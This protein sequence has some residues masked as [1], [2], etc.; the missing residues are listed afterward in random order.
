MDVEQLYEELARIVSAL[1]ESTSVVCGDSEITGV[2]IVKPYT[3]GA[4]QR[5]SFVEMM[6]D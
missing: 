4:Y 6:T 3:L 1:M 5:H 2:R